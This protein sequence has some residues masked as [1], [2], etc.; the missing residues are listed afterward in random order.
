MAVYLASPVLNAPTVEGRLRDGRQTL[1]ATLPWLRA[2][3]A[4]LQA[5]HEAGVWHGALHPA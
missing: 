4:G 2:I 5:A 3:T 1:E